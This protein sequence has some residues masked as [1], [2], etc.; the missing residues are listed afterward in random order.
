VSV[1]FASCPFHTLNE[2]KNKH[3]LSSWIFS[4][5]ILFLFDMPINKNFPRRVKIE[6]FLATGLLA[7]S[8]D[9]DEMKFIPEV[10]FQFSH[11]DMP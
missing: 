8:I 10:F 4:I 3:R 2:N 7:K 9:D 11:A 1:N 6:I 5:F